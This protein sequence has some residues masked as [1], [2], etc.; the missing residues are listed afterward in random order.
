MPQRS[1]QGAIPADFDPFAN[2]GQPSIPPPV[3]AP[4][5]GGAGGAFGAPAPSPSLDALFGLGPSTSSDPLAGN[6]PLAAPA[7]ASPFK[8]A[9]S[10]D[11]MAAFQDKPA[12][13]AAPAQRNNVPELQGSFV[14]PKAIPATEIIAPARREPPAVEPVPIQR[15][16]APIP[17]QAP[18][19][20]AAEA[21]VVAAAP[22]AAIKPAPVPT[23]D[24]PPESAP[25]A[26]ED[27]DALAATLRLAVVRPGAD[28]LVSAFLRGAGVENLN[29][30]SGLTPQTMHLMGQVMRENV[31]AILDLLLARAMLKRELR[32]EVTMIVAQENNPLKFSPNVETALGHLLAPQRGYMEPLE[33]IKDACNDLRSNQFA[34]M[35]GMRAALAGILQRFNPEQLEK[36]LKQKSMLDSL[37]P[38]SRK[39]KMWDLFSDL[40]EDVSKEAED[41]F[42]QLFGREFLR[43]Y[44]AQV[45]KLSRQDRN[46]ERPKNG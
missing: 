16:P 39:A 23:P 44:E 42:H 17:M 29:L 11:P 25:E 46:A 7:A 10:L 31:Q 4:L 41:D 28:E 14:P 43:A 6:G 2:L 3:Q 5:A 45:A 18:A 35:A 8:N 33:A 27:A 32:A 34:F 19:P 38:G 26:S 12:P 21:K 9:P 20:I 15:G 24:V 30:P 1:A 36:R 40:Y 22:A 13:S 37:L